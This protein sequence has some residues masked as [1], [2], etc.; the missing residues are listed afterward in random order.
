LC[1][2]ITTQPQHGA[3]A[4]RALD[5]ASFAD[6]TPAPEYLGSD[7]FEMRLLPDLNRTW[8]LSGIVGREGFNVPRPKDLAA[9]PTLTYPRRPNPGA[10]P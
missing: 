10:A 8:T 6:D 1:G 9:P 7:R 5:R 4:L 2:D 3:V